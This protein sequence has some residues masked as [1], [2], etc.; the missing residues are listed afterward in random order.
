[1]A[2]NSKKKKSTLL[3]R[4]DEE[5]NL[6]KMEQHEILRFIFLDFLYV[7]SKMTLKCRLPIDV[8]NRVK[9]ILRSKAKTESEPRMEIVF[10]GIQFEGIVDLNFFCTLP[11]YNQ[12]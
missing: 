5:R 12:R 10:D 8:A 2:L 11:Q 1:M 3:L 7:D 6:A 9:E 4:E